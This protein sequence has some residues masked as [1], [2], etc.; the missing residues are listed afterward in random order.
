MTTLTLTINNVNFLP[1]YKTGSA[2]IDETSQNQGNTCHLIITKKAAQSAP[3]VGSEFIFKDGTRYL[4]GGY[5]TKVTPFEYGI[6]ELIE[7]Q[8][9][10]SDYTQLLVNKQAQN[11]YAGATLHDIVV[12]LITKGIDPSY[13]I[14]TS[15]VATGPTITTVAFNHIPIRQCFENLAKLTGFIWWVGYDKDIHFVDPTATTTAPETITD[16]VKNHS[17]VSIAV[18]STQVRNVITVLGGTQESNNYTQPIKGDGTARS[19]ILNYPVTTLVSVKLNGVTKTVGV[20]NV[21]P[22]TSFY[23]MYDATRGS[24]RLSAASTVLSTSDL[25]EVIFTYPIPVIIEVPGAVEIATMKALEGGD[26]KHAYTIT[27]STILSKLQAQ[28]RALTEIIK[29]GLPIVSGEVIT[30]TGLLQAGS[31]FIPGQIITVNLP[32][33]NINVDTPLQI[34]N[35]HTAMSE[36][37]SSIEYTYT[38]TIGGRLLGLMDLLQALATPETP[39]DVTNEVLQIHSISEAVTMADSAPTI[40]KFTPPYKWSNDAGTTIGKGIFN[41]SEWS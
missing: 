6:G 4:F 3:T 17:K 32:S 13:A 5:I 36:T 24:I 16:T 37:G 38:L 18:D 30:R 9:E 41:K 31:Y 20:D 28:Q 7:Y 1:Q 19:W 2:S 29:Y 21:D 35:M 25:L 11:S 15:N 40:I 12:D 34:Q 26:G 27:D 8:V 33:W 14:T 23:F 22:E 10:V 39:T